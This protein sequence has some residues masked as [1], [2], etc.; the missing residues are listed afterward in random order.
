MEEDK[1]KKQVMVAI[2]ESEC[3]HYAL[4]WT[5]DNLHDTIVDSHLII[6]TVQSA[7]D[8][9]YIFATSYGSAPPELVTS[10][11]ERNKKVAVALLERAKDIC[12]KHEIEAEPLMEIGD[13]KEKIC[14]AVDKFNIQLLV[15][16]SHGRGAIKRAFLGSVSSY[17]V[18]HAK[19]PVLVVKKND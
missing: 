8:V 10:I 2:D 6:F 9:G 17:C 18:N 15:L 16:G 5:L 7:V 4:Q 11:Q 13:P 12:S 1:K 19:C 14:E 3:S